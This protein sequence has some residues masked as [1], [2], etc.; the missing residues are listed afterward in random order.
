MNIKTDCPVLCT[1]LKYFRVPPLP[2]EKKQKAD[3][4]LKQPQMV[5]QFQAPE[6]TYVQHTLKYYGGGNGDGQ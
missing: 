4:P 2:P 1:M 3:P 6:A 5:D